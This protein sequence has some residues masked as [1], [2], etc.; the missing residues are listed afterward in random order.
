MWFDAAVDWHR[1]TAVLQ[2]RL[3]T[4][5]PVFSQRPIDPRLPFGVPHWED[6][7][8]F[9]LDR[10]LTH[11]TLPPPGDEA[12]LRTYVEAQ[13]H[14]P[15]DREHPLWEIHLVDGYRGGAAILSRFHHALADGIALSQLLVSL[16]DAAP[17]GDLD[18]TL[19]PAVDPVELPG[20]HGDPTADRACDRPADQSGDRAAALRGATARMTGTATWA[21]R[22]ALRLCSALPR[23]VEPSAPIHA[24]RLA[25]QLGQ[26]A[27]KL[28]LTSNPRTQLSGTP[29]IAK[30]VAWS[31]PRPLPKVKRVGRLAGATVNDVLVAAVSEAISQYLLDHDGK[32]VDLTTMVPV[33]VR[34]LDRPL[35]RELGNRFALVLLQLPTG[36]WAPVDRLSEA[37]R[38]MDAVK[39]SPEVAVTFGLITAIG[40][41][42]PELERVLVEFF[43]NKAFGVTTNV[44]GP[45]SVRYLAGTAIAG[46]LGWV[47]G[48]GNQSLGVCIYTYNDTVRVGFK[49][50]AT[51]VPEPDKLVFA[52]ETA[53]DGLLRL[54]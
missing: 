14:R 2:R 24:L 23:L 25:G 36:A 42:T 46:M 44:A 54:G 50:D 35:P 11:V 1:L 13:L 7:P 27:T 30:R 3:L 10:H 15:L 18:E 34:P 6:D 49:V 51:L 40:R 28:M 48:T 26:T 21:G 8:G 16:T 33:N 43:S 31:G 29:G 39:R 38:R 17:N 22:A 5:Y 12:E 47:P 19:D 45:R 20:R 37:K 52:F 53:I 32:A 4:R 41:T 9:C